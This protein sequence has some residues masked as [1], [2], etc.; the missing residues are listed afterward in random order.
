VFVHPM[1]G[2]GVATEI[3][4][5]SGF[6]FYRLAAPLWDRLWHRKP[7][8]EAQSALR[9]GGGPARPQT[10]YR[11]DLAVIGA[12]HGAPRKL[13][14]APFETGKQCH[15]ALVSQPQTGRI[16]ANVAGP[17]ALPGLLD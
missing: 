9:I 1:Q 13:G 14:N 3:P 11:T 8:I 6:S 16:S 17:L 5:A 4:A 2:E 10:H 12:M 7:R 15:R